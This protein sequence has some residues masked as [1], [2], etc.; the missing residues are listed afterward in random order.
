MGASAGPHF[1][2]IGVKYARIVC[3]SVGGEKFL[4]LRVQRITVVRA[5]LLRHADAAV[6]LQR[7]FERL[8]RLHA[9][10]FLL[11]FV[12]IAGR[13]GGDGGDHLRVHIQ[14]ASCFPFLP[15][16]LHDLIPEILCIL[17]GRGE[18]GLIPVI[19]VVI[20]LN[21]VAHVDLALPFPT[22]KTIPFCPQDFL[23]SAARGSM[24]HIW[25]RAYYGA[26]RLL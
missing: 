15:G 1:R 9:D 2:G 12:Q 17:C 13:V 21:E 14:D 4:N 22:D 19:R 18:K 6:G 7:A 25:W 16:Q 11:L 20:F 10:D 23:L 26:G 24:K 8:V 5:G 3:L